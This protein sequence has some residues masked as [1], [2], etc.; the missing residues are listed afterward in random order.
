M[1]V[2]RL[3]ALPPGMENLSS[4]ARR[5]WAARVAVWGRD[6]WL[7]DYMVVPSV[8]YL[9]A[10]DD[11]DP[12]APL[13]DAGLTPYHAISASCPDCG[14]TDAPWSSGSAVS[15]PSLSR[16]LSALSCVR[17]VAVDVRDEALRLALDAGTHAVVSGRDLSRRFYGRGP[18]PAVPRSSWAG[19][20]RCHVGTGRRCR[21]SGR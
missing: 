19:R 2:R 21:G 9:V 10:I 13:T 17:V 11:L 12:A 4:A 1:E 6:G 20:F 3:L 18:A 7:A 15:A 16:S 5:S 14:R 8:R